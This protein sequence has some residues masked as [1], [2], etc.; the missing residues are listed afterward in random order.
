METKQDDIRAG[1][2]FGWGP[3]SVG[4]NYSQSNK[5]SESNLDVH[6]AEVRIKGLQLVAFISALFPLTANPSPD[7]KKWI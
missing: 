1:A 4:G 6:G 7:V 2:S 3:F 5:K